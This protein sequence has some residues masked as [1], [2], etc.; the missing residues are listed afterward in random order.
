MKK[1]IK[2]ILVGL[3]VSITAI[4]V[5]S[6]SA[7][8]KNES[9]P[10]QKSLYAQ[11]LEV[12][13]L[14]D[15]MIQTEEYVDLHTGSSEIKTIIQNIGSGNYTT[16]KAVYSISITEENLIAL[17]EV[18][19]LNNASEELK[20]FLLQRVLETLMTQINGMSGVENLAASSVCTVGK[21]FAVGEDKAV[22]AT[23]VF[24]MYDGF[25][26]GS[27]EEIKEFFSDIVVEVA[28]VQIEK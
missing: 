21:T 3:A 2:K 1:I 19:S 23:G 17:S 14:M 22:T 11:G 26:C 20:D 7:C 12:V 13:K 4:M 27:A 16:P 25:T 24:V 5:L 10:E 15:E 8:G 9:K 28:E 18:D 6:L